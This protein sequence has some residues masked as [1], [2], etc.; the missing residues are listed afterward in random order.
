MRAKE[1]YTDRI[2]IIR[3]FSQYE[4]FELYGVGWNKRIGGFSKA[5]QEAAQKVYKGELAYENKSK[6]KMMNQFKFNICFENCEFP[7]YV[8]EKIFDSLLSG[9]IPVYYGAP[10][11]EEFIPKETFIDY[12][13]LGSPEELDKYLSSLTEKEG[14]EMINAAWDFISSK[15]FDKYDMRSF[16]KAIVNKVVLR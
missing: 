15:A 11:I 6:L 12:R 14:T 2:K 9:S 1:I 4:D 7:G 3:H 10:N 5:Y 13:Q 16:V 8:T